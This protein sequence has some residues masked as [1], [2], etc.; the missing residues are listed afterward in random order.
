VGLYVGFNQPLFAVS[1]MITMVV[2]YDATG[3]RRQAGIHATLI[4]AFIND[5]AA[6][7]PLKGEQLREVL[8][9]TPLEAVAGIILG[10][11]VAQITWWVWPPI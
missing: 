8:G 5:L 6:G 3:I 7:H 1:A 10:I 9:H 2:V 4:N 11:V